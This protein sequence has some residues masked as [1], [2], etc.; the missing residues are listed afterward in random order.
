MID[1]QNLANLK[2]PLGQLPIQL[3]ES[4]AG[5]SLVI[6]VEIKMVVPIG[7]LG[8]HD[9]AFTN[10][11][12][13]ALVE[14]LLIGQL[15]HRARLPRGSIGKV[16]IAVLVITGDRLDPQCLRVHPAKAGNVVLSG[17]N[18]QLNPYCFPALGAHH[19]HANIGIRVAGLRIALQIHRCVGWNP[20]GDRILRHRRLVHLQISQILRV[21]R[22]EIVAANIQLLFVDPIHLAVESCRIVRGCY[23]RRWRSVLLQ[24]H[25]GEAMLAYIGDKIAV[26]RELWIIARGCSRIPDLHPGSLV[27]VVEPEPAVG[28]E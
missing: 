17:A 21:R 22:P 7:P 10:G 13:V 26:G 14:E 28:V 24:T 5:V 8:Q 12:I 23:S 2:I 27:N 1:A 11:D 20:V 15:Q 19:A 16:E 3:C 18:R 6:V 9:N 4:R 25:H